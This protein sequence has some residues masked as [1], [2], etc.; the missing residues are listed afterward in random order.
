MQRADALAFRQAA[1]R[2]ATGVADTTALRF[3]DGEVCG[4]TANSFV[5]ISLS[6]RTVLV[7]VKTRKIAWRRCRRDGRYGVEVLPEQAEEYRDIFAGWSRGDT[8]RE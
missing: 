1:S 3:P 6:P 2:F 8:Y 7:S 4:M 5:T